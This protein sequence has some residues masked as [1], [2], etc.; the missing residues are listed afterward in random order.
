[1]NIY[2]LTEKDIMTED[3]LREIM[4]AEK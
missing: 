2:E 4:E 3:E 1:M